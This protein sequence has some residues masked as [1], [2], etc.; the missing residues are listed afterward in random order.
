MGT[1]DTQ[2]SYMQ[3][4]LPLY[5]SVSLISPS[6][7]LLAASEGIYLYDLPPPPPPGAC[8]EVTDLKPIWNTYSRWLTRT[9]L[10]S[11]PVL[12]NDPRPRVRC[13]LWTGKDVF[14]LDFPLGPTAEDSR[15]MLHVVHQHYNHAAISMGFSTGFQYPSA[16]RIVTPAFSLAYGCGHTLGPGHVRLGRHETSVRKARVESENFL[17]ST[18]HGVAAAVDVSVDELSGRLAIVRGSIRRLEIYDMA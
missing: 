6:R 4:F 10:I 9:P 14:D 15:F 18:E 12:Y 13:M 2:C 16:K 3:D 8:T 11:Q 1:I 7:L 5:G 17:G